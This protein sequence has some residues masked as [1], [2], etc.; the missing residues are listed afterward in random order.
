MSLE[1]RINQDLKAAMLAGQPERVMTLR[2]LKSSLLYAKVAAGTRDQEMADDEVL[3]ILAKESKKR[4][5]SADLY[6]TGGDEARATQELAEKAL[7]DAYLPA[8]LPESEL[9]ELVETAVAEV[10]ATTPAQMGQ[11]IA[12]VRQ[13]AGAAADGAVIARLVKERLQQ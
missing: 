1:A 9:Q 8:Q 12:K 10:G 6:Q 5:E 3:A 11:V 4:Q 2:S 13:Q 7:I